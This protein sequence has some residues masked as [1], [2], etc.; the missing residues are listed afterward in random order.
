[1]T[2]VTGS[3]IK[4]DW[5]A[6]PVFL[7]VALLPAISAIPFLRKSYKTYEENKASCHIPVPAFG[8]IWF[9]VHSA[10]GVAVYFFWNLDLPTEPIYISGMTLWFFSSFILVLWPPTFF[11]I[12]YIRWSPPIA[13]INFMFSGTVMGLF[14]YHSNTAGGL[15][16]GLVA[17]EM[18]KVWMSFDLQRKSNLKRASQYGKVEADVPSQTQLSVASS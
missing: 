5:V 13:L 10:S 18:A 12:I 14:F 8:F 1:M 6:L 3:L 15:M 7:M 17:W 2:Y 11:S 4:H 9:I 16:T